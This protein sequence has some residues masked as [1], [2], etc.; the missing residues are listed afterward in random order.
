MSWRLA[1]EAAAEAS[2]EEGSRVRSSV[3][4]LSEVREDQSA[5]TASTRIH[6]TST[7][8]EQSPPHL[9]HGDQ[10]RPGERGRREAEAGETRHAVQQQLRGHSLGP[11]LDREVSSWEIISWEVSWEVSW[12]VQLCP[13]EVEV[14]EGVAPDGGGEEAAE[15]GAGQLRVGE[16]QPRH[17]SMIMCCHFLINNGF[18][19]YN[20]RTDIEFSLSSDQTLCACAASIVNVINYEQC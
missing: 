11:G 17:L 13:G 15:L 4:R 8:T 19:F 18:A 2:S 16:V 14:V 1:S 9:Q 7:V 10:L 3:E 5:V 6:G 12:C 20:I